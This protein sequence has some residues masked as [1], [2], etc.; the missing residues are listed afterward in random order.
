M[1]EL[2]PV[3]APPFFGTILVTKPQ[4]EADYIIWP[5]PHFLRS[6]PGGAPQTGLANPENPNLTEPSAQSV[7]TGHILNW[8]RGKPAIILVGAQT[9]CQTQCHRAAC[10]GPLSPQ[11]PLRSTER[12]W[13]VR[14]RIG[15]QLLVGPA[16]YVQQFVSAGA[17]GDAEHWLV[18]HL[19]PDD[20]FQI[21]RSETGV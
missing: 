20:P 14:P 21:L 18:R 16:Q 1:S 6:S 4:I 8:L 13:G 5:F 10:S 9:P 2:A 17:L 11:S 3:T 19:G 7:K 15:W 12:S